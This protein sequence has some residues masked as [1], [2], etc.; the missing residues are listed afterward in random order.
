M[1]KGGKMSVKFPSALLG[2]KASEGAQSSCLPIA[3]AQQ[4]IWSLD[5]ETNNISTLSH[6]D[7]C[8]GRI[9]PQQSVLTLQPT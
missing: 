3:D 4:N 6:V 5:S 8:T 9:E 7:C 2:I 1:Y